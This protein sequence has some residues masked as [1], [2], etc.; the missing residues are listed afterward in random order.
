MGRAIKIVAAIASLW[1]TSSVAAAAPIPPGS[2]QASCRDIYADR[3]TLTATCR[4]Q[5]GEWSY[6]TLGRYRDCQGDIVNLNGR[7]RCDGDWSDDDDWLP[8]GSYRATCRNETLERGTLTAECKDHNGRWR[9]TELANA[10]ACRGDILNVDG[11]LRCQ[12]GG[13]ETH[14][15]DGDW[16][17]SCRKARIYG[18]VLYAECRTRFGQWRETSLDLR[19]CDDEV[20]NV[21]GR[22]VCRG[23]DGFAQVTLY[24]H[25]NFGGKSRTFSD[26]VADLNAYAFGNQASSVVVQGGVWQLC[27]RPNY[28]GYCIVVDRTHANLLVF[29]FNDRVE[30]VRRVR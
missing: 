3:S 6:T 30:S 29:G 14:L 27:D 1:L 26:D 12:R 25:T 11:I 20:S 21:G 16:R 24:K 15:P 19:G 9:Y 10:S 2:Y 22:L 18:F 5:R 7:L 23:D 28:R 8:P 4:T 13:G 17:Y